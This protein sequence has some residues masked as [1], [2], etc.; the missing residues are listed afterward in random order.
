[1]VAKGFHRQH[2][3]ARL[4]RVQTA[5][6]RGDGAAA[7]RLLAEQ[8]SELRRSLLTR[9]Q[10]LRVESR[11]CAARIAV[12]QAGRHGSQ[13]R[14]LSVARDTPGAS[15]ASGCHGPIPLR[16][17]YEPGLRISKATFRSPRISP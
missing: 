10:V 16:C 13:R 11:T 2:Y 9:V 14:I 3:S 1:M 17:W 7:W 6:Y 4:A 12:A 15:P 8:H 5:L